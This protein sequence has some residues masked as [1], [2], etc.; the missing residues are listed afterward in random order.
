MPSINSLFT[1]QEQD[2]PEQPAISL[3]IRKAIKLSWIAVPGKK[4][5]IQKSSDLI[6]WETMETITATSNRGIVYVDE[7]TER[8]H[9]RLAPL[10]S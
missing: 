7:S 4:Y 3:E 2:I 8:D 1:D 5:E 9:F 6:N 10:D